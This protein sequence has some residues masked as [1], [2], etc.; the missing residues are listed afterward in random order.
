M[1][2][3]PDEKGKKMKTGKSLEELAVTIKEQAAMKLDFIAPTELFNL[4]LSGANRL[5]LS[6]ALHDGNG[7]QDLSLSDTAMRNIADYCN[8]PQKYWNYLMKIDRVEA[9]KVLIKCVDYGMSQAPRLQK[10]MF[11]TY[12]STIVPDTLRCMLSPSYRRLDNDEVAETVFPVLLDGNDAGRYEIISSEITEKKLYIKAVNKSLQKDISRGDVVESG[13]IIRNSETGE[14]MFDIS[15]FLHF[16]Y[17]DNGMVVADQSMKT[18]HLMS[19][20]ANDNEVY[21]MLSDE[22]KQ[23]ENEVILSKCRDVLIGCMA[24]EQFERN[25]NRLVEAKTQVI[26]KPLDTVN[27]LSKNFGLSDNEKESV[28]DRIVNKAEERDRINGMAT[29]LTFINAFTN[30]G[31]DLQDYDRATDFQQTGG[32][33]LTMLPKKLSK[34]A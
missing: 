16:L 18:R 28:L 29:M 3:K 1:N 32:L 21:Q 6:K 26:E 30:V 7:I 13:I 2:W 8:I 15:P 31:N 5:L 25:V 9:Y 12:T 4:S 10:R 11:R 20:Q 33:I 24:Q 17:C 23:K 34:V 14:G 22:T 27:I 19:S